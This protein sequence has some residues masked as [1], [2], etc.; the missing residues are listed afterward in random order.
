MNSDLLIKCFIAFCIGTIIYK[1]ILDRCSCNV[2]E[3][4]TMDLP[5]MNDIR[6]AVANATGEGGSEGEETP[7]AAFLGSMSFVSNSG[8]NVGN[9]VINVDMI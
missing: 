4:Q 3:G 5:F 9:E 2:V 8:L 7:P 1:F 6:R